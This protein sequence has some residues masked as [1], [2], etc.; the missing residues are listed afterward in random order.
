MPDGSFQ[1]TSF[2]GVLLNPWAQLQYA[3]T[4][5]GAV[6]T[7]AF[8]VAAVGAFYLLNR[9]YEEYGRIFVRVGV[10]AGVIFSILQLFPTGDAHGRYL[11][12]NQPV[13]LAA[14]EALWKS[15]RGAPVVLIG[16]PD[17]ERE[18]I[19]N[20]VAV[21]K[22]LSFLIYGSF[23]AEVKG[24]DDY[25]KEDWPQNIPLL[26]FS[27]HIMAGL[28]TIFIGVMAVAPFLL[29]RGRLFQARW[30]LW[31]LLLS[32]PLPYIAN[33]AGW[34]TAELGRQPWLVY[35]L[36][37]TAEGFSP[38]VSSGNAW[39]TLLGFMGIYTV[40]AIFCLFLILRVIQQGPAPATNV[41][42]GKVA[43]QEQ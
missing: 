36:L 12:K 10:V 4:M 22:A 25:P 27:Y 42:L 37:R 29:W 17:V 34:L 28:G 8:A 32:V 13:A 31:I 20:P 14:M 33:T 3:H 11:A 38:T 24:L 2:W 5:S 26:Y 43:T 41:A 40:L 30:M 15:Q 16:Q 18:R 9:R 1:V 35:G 39:F 21:N 6:I 23:G 7:G 19:D